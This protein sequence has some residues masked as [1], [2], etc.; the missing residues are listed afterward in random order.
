MTEHRVV[1]CQRVYTL[2]DFLYAYAH[3]LCHGLLT[4]QIVRYELVERWVEQA[5]VHVAAIHCLEN[6]V[7]VSLLI[8]EKLGKSLLATLN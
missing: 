8:W 3:L 1:L 4:S 6:A 7:E 5:D 2:L